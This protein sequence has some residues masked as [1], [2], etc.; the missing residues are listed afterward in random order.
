V[1]LTHS[2]QPHSKVMLKDPELVILNGEP[3]D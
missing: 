3:K 2:V 1:W